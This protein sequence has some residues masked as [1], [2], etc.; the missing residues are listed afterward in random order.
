M[1]EYYPMEGEA[2]RDLVKKRFDVKEECVRSENKLQYKKN[3]LLKSKDYRKWEL[4]KESMNMISRLQADEELARKHM[5]PKESKQV[6]DKQYL[7]NYFSNQV[8]DQ[9]K[10]NLKYNY[11]DMLDHMA[12]VGRDQLTTAKKSVQTWENFIDYFEK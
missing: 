12:S 5:L 1:D 6:M 7:L 8:N 3:S 2:M 11:N 10:Q 4:S 9:I